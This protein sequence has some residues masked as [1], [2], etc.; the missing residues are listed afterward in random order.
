MDEEL[1]HTFEKIKSVDEEI[2]RASEQLARLERDA[3]RNRPRRGGTALRGFVG[4]GLAAG[5]GVAAFVSQSSHGDTVRQM[6]AGWAPLHAATSSQLQAEPAREAETSP[7]AQLAEASPQPASAAETIPEV[8]APTGSTLPP[9]LTE[10]LQK[11]ASDL[12][13]VQQG[14]DQLK[15]SQAQLKANQDQM[16]LDSLRLADELKAGQEQMARLVA[17]VPGDKASENKTPDNKMPEIAGKTTDRSNAGQ[18]TSAAPVPAP[19]P[20]AAQ[21]RKPAPATSSPHAAARRPAPVQLQ[22]ARQ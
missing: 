11:L 13:N 2:A 10:L 12:A 19:R 6:I 8:V 17:K 22:S 9:E 5:I 7:T 1:T 4:L 21:T 16:S 20:A 15:A 3:V 18:K 14:I